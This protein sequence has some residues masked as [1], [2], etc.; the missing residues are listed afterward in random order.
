[1]EDAKGSKKRYKRYMTEREQKSGGSWK[2]EGSKQ[3]AGSE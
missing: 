3:Q 2:G 1:M